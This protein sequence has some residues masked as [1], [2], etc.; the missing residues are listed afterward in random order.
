MHYQIIKTQDTMSC[1]ESVIQ[2]F[3]RNNISIP[4]S[5]YPSLSFE[6]G[7]DGSN[8]FVNVKENKKVIGR[9]SE[10]SFKDVDEVLE[11][12]VYFCDERYRK[13]TYDRAMKHPKLYDFMTNQLLFNCFFNEAKPFDYTAEAHIRTVWNRA[14]PKYPLPPDISKLRFAWASSG[15]SGADL[16]V[17]VLYRDIEKNDFISEIVL[18]NDCVLDYLDCDA[19]LRFAIHTE[20]ENS[21]DML[22]SIFFPL[23]TYKRVYG[24]T[25]ETDFRLMKLK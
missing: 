19:L 11:F 6:F 8:F 22:R 13:K 23:L 12:S 15:V 2:I 18:D 24:D 20:D 4:A 14:N 10:N 9:L 16:A 17:L 5:N 3:N 1:L 7:Y 21:F 25:E